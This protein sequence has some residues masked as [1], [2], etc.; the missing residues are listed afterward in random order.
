VFDCNIL[1]LNKIAN[2]SGNITVVHNTQEIPFEVKR[3]F[4]I[5][6]IPGGAS[7]GAHSHLTSHQFL[8]AA[9]G[10]FEIQLDDGTLKRKVRL[11]RPF[12]GLHIP[13]LIWASEINFSSGSVC[14]ALASTL[15]DADDYIRDYSSFLS[16]RENM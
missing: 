6:D 10:S 5:Y 1:Y 8:V 14:L 9:S 7:R 4:Y 15:Y 11:N 3:L 13:P 16:L 12:L 2:R